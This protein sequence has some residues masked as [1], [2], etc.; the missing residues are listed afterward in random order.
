MSTTD[1]PIAWFLCGPS[2]IGKTIVRRDILATSPDAIVASSDDYLESLATGLNLTFQEAYFK[3]RAEAQRAFIGRLD[4][5][6]DRWRDVIVDRTNLSA[7]IRGVAT[8]LLAESHHLVALVPGCDFETEDATAVLLRRATSR[9]DRPG[10][11]IP[12]SNILQQ[13]AAWKP[14]TE[15]EGFAHV[16]ACIG[17]PG[18]FSEE[19]REQVSWSIEAQTAD[20][21][22]P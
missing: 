5:A 14:P 10:P 6:I 12:A 9:T 8:S 4:Q 22:E 19:L 13:I 18:G 17:I 2:G 20:A 16:A 11:P 15:E 3:F 1:R 21:L 7:G